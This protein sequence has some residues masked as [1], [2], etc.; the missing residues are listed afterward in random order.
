MANHVY[1]YMNISTNVD[2]CQ[3]EWDKLFTNYHEEV[4]RPSY[5][6]D[7]TITM[8]EYKEIQVHP[9]F[10]GY[11]DDN[12]YNWGIENI[13][14]KWAHIEDAD[15]SSAYIVSA[16]SPI[17]PYLEALDD[18]L[19]ELDEA[20]IIS[21]QYEDEFRNFIGVAYA[22][23][24]GTSGFDEL[25]GDDVT[26]WLLDPLNIDEIP[27]DFEWWEPHPALD[28]WSPQEYLDEKVNEWFN[29]V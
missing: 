20:V 24:D 14:A 17:I 10:E 18:H 2:A 11:S 16:W 23:G 6:G 25:D 1:H 29:E 19:R 3:Q 4:E 9:M 26:Q 15:D 28:G 8:R 22:H 5:H 27:D 12:W 21:C 13:G 7:G